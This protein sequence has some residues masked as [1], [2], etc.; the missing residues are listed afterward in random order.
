MARIA[1]GLIIANAINIKPTGKIEDYFNGQHDIKLQQVKF[2]G[3]IEDRI[4][5]DYLRILRYFRFQ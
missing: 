3:P 2:I 4:Q 5:E 1:S